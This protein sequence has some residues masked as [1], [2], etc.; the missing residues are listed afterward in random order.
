[1]REGVLADLP[2]QERPKLHARVAEVIE[3]VYPNRPEQYAAL[4]YH[5]GQTDN[6]SKEVH[7]AHQAGELSLRNS[8]NVDAARQYRSALTALLKLPHTPE[9]V[10]TELALQISLSVALLSIKGYTAPEVKQAWTRAH[11]LSR[12]VEDGPQYFQTLWGLW[13]FYVVQPKFKQAL[14]LAQQ[15]F[16]SAERAQDRVFLLVGH[17]VLGVTYYGMGDLQLA[18]THLEQSVALYKVQEDRSLAFQYGQDPCV[19][20]LGWLAFT[21][22]RLGYTDLA[23]QR[24]Q[25]AITLAEGLHHM[26]S[27]TFI[28]GNATLFYTLLHD[29]KAVT[30]GI[31]DMI[32]LSTEQGFILWMAW[33]H[34]LRG[35]VL[36]QSGQPNE[37]I[38]EFTQGMAIVRMIGAEIEIPYLLSLQAEAYGLA[39][40][41]D[42]GLTAIEQALATISQTEEY[43]AEPE[44]YRIKGELLMRL[45][46]P[47]AEAHFEKAIAIARQQQSKS[48]ELRATISRCRLWENQGK[49]DEAAHALRAINHWFTEN[50]EV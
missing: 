42:E 34:C 3:V 32:R 33:G 49:K 12:E 24:M 28:L 7:Y 50:T 41:A 20:S 17:W 19:T 2:I 40:Q 48:W 13:S 46:R 43:S 10:Q 25:E 39:G 5:W 38:A 16:A 45:G 47:E 26:F 8:A 6:A 31:E 23:R 1:L 36:T 4:A 37:A 22:W 18:K 14:E 11:E 29:V 30:D 15:M 35:W 21:L 27:L 44:L 9:R